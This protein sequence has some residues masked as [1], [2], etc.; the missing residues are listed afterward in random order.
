M[1]VKP[2]NPTGPSR[3]ATGVGWLLGSIIALS[4]IGV[5]LITTSVFGPVV[6]A[7]GI[8]VGL[9]MALGFPI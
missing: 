8:A 1:A 4:S 6:V 2:T 7:F 5:G 3:L 9:A